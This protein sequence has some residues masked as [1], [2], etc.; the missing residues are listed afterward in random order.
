[1]TDAQLFLW[2]TVF[3]GLSLFGFF[4][5]YKMGWFRGYLAAGKIVEEMNDN[6]WALLAAVELE[7]PEFQYTGKR[8]RH[9]D[10]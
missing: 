9:K 2:A 8:S 6:F 5:G 7:Y 10:G 4:C 3:L 1:M